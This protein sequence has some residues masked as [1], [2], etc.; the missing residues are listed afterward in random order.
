MAILKPTAF[1]KITM[2]INM[3]KRSNRANNFVQTTLKEESTNC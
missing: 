1:L 3:I 2:L